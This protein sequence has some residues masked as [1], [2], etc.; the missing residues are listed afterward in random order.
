MRIAAGSN[1][2]TVVAAAGTPFAAKGKAAIVHDGAQVTVD[3]VRSALT[4]TVPEGAEVVIGT[5]SGR[6]ECRG[7][8]GA[9][10]VTTTS[11]RVDVDSAAAVDVRSSSGMVHVGTVAGTCRV[12]AVS[13][14]VRVE[15]AGDADVSTKSGRIALIDVHGPVSVHSVSGHVAVAMRRAADVHAET[16]SGRI[17]LRMPRTDSLPGVGGEAPSQRAPVV[18]T[19]S[20]TGRVVVTY[21]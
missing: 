13:G 3:Q 2:V 4:V 9:L 18:S 12:H 15:S 10:A 6:V 16:V 1:R 7:R 5:S 14:Q 21:E 8:L 19:R 11:G 20:T 17:E